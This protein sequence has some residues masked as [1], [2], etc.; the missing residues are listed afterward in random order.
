MPIAMPTL[1]R[2]NKVGVE[3]EGGWDE[4]PDGEEV[5]E[6]GSVRILD[7][8]YVGEVVSAPLNNMD[9]LSR[10]ARTVYPAYTDRSCGL[11]VHVSLNDQNDM[12]L[13]AETAF[14]NYYLRYMESWCGRINSQ[15]D[16]LRLHIRLVGDERYC[17]RNFSPADQLDTDNEERYTQ[18][19]FCAWEK[20]GTLEFRVLPMFHSISR[21]IRGIF[22]IIRCVES[23]L[24]GVTATGRTARL[25]FEE[26]IR[27]IE[28]APETETEQ[29]IILP[30]VDID[31]ERISTFSNPQHE[32]E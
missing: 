19:N 31:M 2:I 11:H 6:D 1:K 21:A 4:E 32:R 29:L 10:W 23:Y 15:R 28:Y 7:V 9:Y 27:L 12:A 24:N 3:L 5:K 8:S 25:Q 13:L 18:L 14:W 16:H 17:A 30:T 20:F 26:V 22:T